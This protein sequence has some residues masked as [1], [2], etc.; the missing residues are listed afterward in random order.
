M[1][2]PLTSDSRQSEAPAITFCQLVGDELF[3]NRRSDGTGWSWRWADWNRGWMDE[4]PGKFAYRCLPLTIANQTG[5][6]IDNPVGFTA[7]WNG[8][9]RPG[10]VSFQFDVDSSFWGQWI[11]DQFG[12]GIVTWNT[13]FLVRT[14]PEGS[15]LLVMGPANLFKPGAQGLTALIETDWMYMSF[16]MNWK[17]TVPN[18]PVRFEAGEPII[19]LVPM[20]SDVFSDLETADVSYVKLQDAPELREPYL[21]WLE[22]RKVFREKLQAGESI[23]E[24]QKNYFQ[25]RDMLGR[26]VTSG[27]RTRLTPPEV[28]YKSPK[29]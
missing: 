4:T 18:L 19:Q 5:W 8:H 13:P 16:T 23:E 25:G 26:P 20:F 2:A 14:R 9:P 11:N 17:I 6:W 15:R 22:T 24:W 3:R 10:C 1:E 27:H 12:Q 21:R 7:T 28:N 29:P